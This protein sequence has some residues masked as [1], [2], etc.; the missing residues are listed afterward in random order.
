MKFI[1]LKLFIAVSSVLLINQV[2]AQAND[3]LVKNNIRLYDS[4]V[5]GIH[6]FPGLWRPVFKTEQIAWISPPWLKTGFIWAG[7]PKATD[8]IWLD[9]PKAIF[10]NKG[11]LFLSHINPSLPSLYNCPEVVQ[12]PWTTLPDGIQYN[13]HLPNGL[14]FGGVVT[15]ENTNTISLELWMKNDTD[16]IIKSIQLLTCAYLNPIE[17]FNEKSNENK[18]VHISG[19]GWITLKKALLMKGNTSKYA[20]GWGISSQ[21]ICDLP[22]IIATSREHNRLMAYTWWQNTGALWGNAFHPSFNADP[23]MPDLAPGQKHTIKGSIIFFEGS[24]PEFETYFKNELS[25]RSKN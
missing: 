4:S 1:G 2:Y 9:F 8:F 10:T 14:K 25:K 13:Q 16:S 3:R 23:F 5:S 24:I 18:F 6:I 19:Q 22:V 7:F 21:K 20:V 11:L 15:K 17:E 12:T